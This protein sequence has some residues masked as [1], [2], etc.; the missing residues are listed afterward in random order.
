M[1]DK[2]EYL[3]PMETWV[4]KGIIVGHKPGNYTEG[5]HGV[6][7]L[8]GRIEIYYGQGYA[9]AWNPVFLWDDL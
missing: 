8:D 2:R 1:S 5:L 7:Y 3:S 4:V 9:G 6:V